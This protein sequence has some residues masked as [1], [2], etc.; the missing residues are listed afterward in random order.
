MSVTSNFGTKP[1]F[2]SSV[3]SS[4][5][6]HPVARSGTTDL[7]LFCFTCWS[8]M[9]RL[10]KITIVARAGDG[11]DLPRYAFSLPAAD[12][13]VTRRGAIGAAGMLLT[14]ISGIGR[15]R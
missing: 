6:D 7:M 10:L 14:S 11:V 5:H 12:G 2:L 15:S 9:T 1:C 8:N 3:P 4:F 13:V